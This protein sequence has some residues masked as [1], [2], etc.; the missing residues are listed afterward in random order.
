MS[1]SEKRLD[2]I[3]TV[4]NHPEEAYEPKLSSETIARVLQNQRRETIC[5]VLSNGSNVTT[6]DELVDTLVELEANASEAE[7]EPNRESMSIQLHHVHLPLLEDIGLIAYENR[8]GTVRYWGHSK[9]DGL[10][11]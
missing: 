3:E 8:C 4:R 1:D 6:L 10:F 2:N 9:I 5:R 7:I 11:D